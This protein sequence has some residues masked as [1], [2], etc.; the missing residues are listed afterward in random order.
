[1]VASDPL[2]PHER[3]CAVFSWL[4]GTNLA[5][6]LTPATM[7]SFGATMARLHLHALEFTPSSSFTASRY[8]DPY[9]YELPF[10]V[11][12]EAGDD[13]LPPDRRRLFEEAWHAVEATIKRL[14]EREPARLLHGDL[15]PW[16]AMVNHGRISVFDFEDVVWGWPVQDIG[17]TLYYFW[18]SE[19]FEERWTQLREGY[20]TVA[21]WPDRGGEVATF[22]AG[23]TLVLA[24]DVISQPEWFSE[25][26]AVYERGE[27]RIRAMLRLAAT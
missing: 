16:N 14:A 22:I 21:P 5:D 3:V 20:E 12:D 24:N 11:F 4:E 18:S 2:V 13:L 6:R 26:H 9:P 7:Q 19:E 10:V 15:H 17:T 23:R 1:M 25:A 27:K 8:D